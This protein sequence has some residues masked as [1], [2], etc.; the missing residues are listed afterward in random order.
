[1]QTSQQIT[2]MIPAVLRR[3]SLLAARPL[4]SGEPSVSMDDTIA[5]SVEAASQ[6]GPEAAVSMES[7]L[8]TAPSVSNS[9]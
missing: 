8:S 7:V 1:M 6:P 2:T 9:Y 3:D 5:T 4:A